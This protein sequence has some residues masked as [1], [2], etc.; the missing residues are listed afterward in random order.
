MGKDTPDFGRI[1]CARWWH[2]SWNKLKRS[3]AN[4][5][6]QPLIGPSLSL[7]RTNLTI[8]VPSTEVRFKGSPALQEHS[9]SAE[10]AVRGMHLQQSSKRRSIFQKTAHLSL[11]QQATLRLR[12][13]KY[14]TWRMKGRTYLQNIS[15]HSHKNCRCDVAP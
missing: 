8:I 14:G 1:I 15:T 12:I 3:W 6:S 13:T 9:C 5:K 2:N 10:S 11:V 7:I 4:L